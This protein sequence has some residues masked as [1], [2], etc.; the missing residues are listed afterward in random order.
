MRS[1]G[2]VTAHTAALERHIAITF[3]F[4]E[5]PTCLCNHVIFFGR[6][7]VVVVFFSVFKLARKNYSRILLTLIKITTISRTV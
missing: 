3:F 6:R 7:N 2:Q 5:P 4:V 1:L